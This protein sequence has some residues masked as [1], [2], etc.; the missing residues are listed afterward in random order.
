M[1]PSLEPCFTGVFTHYKDALALPGEHPS[2]V[3]GR[4]LLDASVLD[5]LLSRFSAVH[6]GGDRRA[7]VSM[8]AQWHFG[9]LIIPTT[10]AALVLDRNL[11]V[12]LDRICI[13]VHE[14][15]RTA[16]VI[17]PDEG[18]PRKGDD[19]ERFASLFRGHIE[20]L[21]RTLAARFKVS[22][23]L[24]WNNAADVF[25]WTL[26]QA[27][28]AGMAKPDVLEE[29]RSLLNDRL[30]AGGAPN[31]MFGLVR[32]VRQEEQ[33]T[34]RRKVCCLR[35]HLPGIACCGS[36]CPLPPPSLTPETT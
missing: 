25:E 4:E 11:P 34:R 28:G 36:I 26:Q 18:V 32:Y 21:I 2:S 17:L 16:A 14:E 27:A 1:I 35:Y 30:W 5:S 10:L 33:E 22:P 24:L 15:G 12:D 3:R 7:L 29:G 31:P 6:P 19:A 23:R 9:A 20:P 8:W 13:A